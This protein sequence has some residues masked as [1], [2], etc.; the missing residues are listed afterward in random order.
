M[1]CARRAA[2]MASRSALGQRV[3]TAARAELSGARE[4][5]SRIPLSTLRIRHTV[6]SCRNPG[7]L[8]KINR[9]K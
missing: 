7:V 9:D 8:A 4:C 3:S 6:T 1:G 5:V 2:R